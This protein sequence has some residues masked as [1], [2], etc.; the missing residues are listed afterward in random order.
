MPLF[1]V[2][3]V[4]SMLAGLTLW[5]DHTFGQPSIDQLLYHW[6]YSEA[7]A[8]R[9]SRIFAVTFMAEVI[10]FPL[11][12]ALGL[13]MLHTI[14][15]RI[16][17]AWTSH[18]AL[19]RLP[20]A[21]AL[22]AA[23]FLAMQFSAFTYA[24]DSFGPDQFS[25]DYVD[26]LAV[27]FAVRAGKPRNLV[28]IYM[29]SIEDAYSNSQIFGRDLLAPL[30]Q[31]EGRSFEYLPAPGT[32]WTIA[33]LVATQCGLP[34]RA[35]S[36]LDVPRKPH[37]KTYLAGATCLGD[38]LS[39]RGY[40][41]VFMGGASLSFS[42]KGTFLADHGYTQTLGRE[43]WIS[44]GVKDVDLNEW[45]VY[46]SVLFARARAQLQELHESGHPFNLTLLTMNT[47]NPFGY[48][49]PGCKGRGV[50]DF[51]ALVACSAVQ[52]R[53]FVD[54]ARSLGYLEDTLFVIVGDHLAV[55]NPVWDK[56]QREPERHIFNRFLGKDLPQP[57]RQTIVPFDVFP[58][59][60]EALGLSV[61]EG[62]V[63][64]GYAGFNHPGLEPPAHRVESATTAALRASTVY[65]SLWRPQW[66]AAYERPRKQ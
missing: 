25:R 16:R 37:G 13:T 10:A 27:K 52:V 32:N 19:R 15:L 51:E 55:P 3:S 54:Y 18:I 66:R 31:I 9:M 65:N 43:Q 33:A 48:L 2:Y 21:G 20:A 29:E 34:L 7:A 57:D 11:L 17:P 61:P 1:Y 24:R 41:N 30:R 23:A 36:E 42:G 4:A 63:A 46:D 58:T 50:R 44:E 26:P 35:Y 53:E 64:L 12:F 22:A 14:V 59:I 6:Q 38:L 40:R 5:I 60:L 47:H 39:E 8:V 28:L 62:R 49:G 56:L 45:G